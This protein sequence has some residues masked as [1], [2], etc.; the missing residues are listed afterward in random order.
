MNPRPDLGWEQGV[1]RGRWLGSVRSLNAQGHLEVAGLRVPGQLQASAV[2]ADLAADHGKAD[3]HAL[4]RG[5]RIPG[6]Q[7]KLLEV[8]PVKIDASIQ[9]NDP[10]RRVELTA[11]HRLFTLKG[12]AVTAKEQSATLELR[13]PNLTPLAAYAGQDL[14]GSAVLNAQLAGYPAA[15]RIKLDANAALT[16]GTANLGRCTG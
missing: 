15:T 16:P 4:I 8:D 12:Q 9:L 2:T 3:L 14:H 10:S 7:P 6:S 1:L 13:V 11:T 5:L